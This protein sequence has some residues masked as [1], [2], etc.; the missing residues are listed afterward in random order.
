MA[1]TTK[2]RMT[3]KRKPRARGLA[4]V[5]QGVRGSELSDGDTIYANTRYSDGRLD[6]GPTG[7]WWAA[8]QNDAAGIPHENT[9]RTV[10]KTEA[11]A[12]AAARAYIMSQ[13]K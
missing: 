3:W 7:W 12:K 13:F 6:D 1:N 10:V 8:P 11:E 9:C 5:V 2:P 4:S